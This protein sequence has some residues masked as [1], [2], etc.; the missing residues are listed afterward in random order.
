MLRNMKIAQR[1]ILTFVVAV[2]IS[3]IAGVLG[4]ALLNKSD[5]DYSTTLVNYGFSQGEIG[6]L[7]RHH[8]KQ[9]VTILLALTDKDPQS[10]IKHLDELAALNN[11]IDG[12][13]A[14]VK[15][16]LGSEGGEKTYAALETALKAYRAGNAEVLALAGTATSDQLVALYTEKCGTPSAEVSNII[17]T[18]LADKTRIGLESSV[19]LSTQTTLFTVVMIVVILV[20]IAVALTFAI[21]TAREISRP[22]RSME[23][24]AASLAKGDFNVTVTYESKNEIGNLA[25]SMRDMVTT[26]KNIISDTDRGLHEIASGNFDIAPRTEY[27]GIYKQIETSIWSIIHKLSE[28]MYQ[29]K[30][31]ADEVASASDQVSTGS[32]ALSQGT[33]EQ[34]SS[35]EELSATITEISSHVKENA[36]HAAD[37]SSKVSLVGRQIVESNSQMQA[38]IVAMAEISRSSSEIGKVIKTIEDIAFQTNILALNAAVEAARAGVAGK[39]FAVVADEVRNLASKSAE[40]AKGTTSL[41]EGSIKAV[42]N[43]TKIADETAKSLEKTV[44]GAQ[45]VEQI[46]ES[47]SSA[48]NNQAN[49]IHQVTIGIDQIS[50]VVQTNSA[51]AEQSAAASEELSGQAQMLKDLI[52][53]FQLSSAFKLGDST[54]APTPVFNDAV[55][56]NF[57]GSSKY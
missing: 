33:T 16:G 55:E 32:Q 3:S 47:I 50:A 1:L 30:N 36:E 39:G 24:A 53:L 43:G 4:V 44:A 10:R 29:I 57:S 6:N 51:T 35:I 20:S 31:A 21:I 34:A 18:M 27:V 45:E 17:D 49:S 25:Q 19:G 2:L 13:M 42:V 12:D 7:G 22:V 37:A 46:V 8:Q 14:L 52:V 48:S 40:A 5:A 38:M 23:V 56:N 9:R 26:T 28:T 54:P 41:I 11:I 15:K